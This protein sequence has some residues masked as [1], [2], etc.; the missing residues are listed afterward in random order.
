[1]KFWLKF[2]NFSRCYVNKQNVMFCK[3]RTC[4]VDASK[5][6]LQQFCRWRR[7][8]CYNGPEQVTTVEQ[9]AFLKCLLIET[10]VWWLNADSEMMS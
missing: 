9:N 6:L 1:M 2:V 5:M 4:V 10:G 3:H 8:S 7:T